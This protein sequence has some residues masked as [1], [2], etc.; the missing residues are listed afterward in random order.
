MLTCKFQSIQP[1]VPQICGLESGLSVQGSLFRS[2]HGSASFHTGHGSG[3]N[4]SASPGYPDTT[5]FRRL[6]YLSSFS[7]FGS[8]GF[9]HGLT[10]MPRTGYCSQLGEI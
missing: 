6:A 2:L 9:G 8:S 4:F 7:S 5:L 1:Q 10:A 3:F